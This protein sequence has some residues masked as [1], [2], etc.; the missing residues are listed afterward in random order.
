MESARSGVWC[1]QYPPSEAEPEETDED[2]Y[3]T[4]IGCAIMAGGALLIAALVK[5]VR[6]LL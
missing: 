6:A 3:Y 5:A 2:R 4:R 1:V